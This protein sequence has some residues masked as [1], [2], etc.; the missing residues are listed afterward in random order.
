VGSLKIEENTLVGVDGNVKARGTG[1]SRQIEADTIIFAIGDTVDRDFCVPI[2]NDAYMSVP[3]PR[4]PVEGISYEAYDPDTSQPIER[5]FLAGWARQAS[6]GLVGV[7]RRDGERAAESVL[8]YLDAQGPMRDVDNVVEKFEQRLVETHERV[9]D[10]AH[11]AKL[12]VAESAEAQKRGLEDFK[13]AT[14]DDMF[15]AMGY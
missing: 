14:N 5:V 7:A 9:V 13:F 3:Q 6:T 12:V 2:F 8:Q 1:N 15:T 10:K 11:L 4:F